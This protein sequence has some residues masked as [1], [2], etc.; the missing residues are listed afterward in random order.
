MFVMTSFEKLLKE[1][2]DNAKVTKEKDL[3]ETIVE[4]LKKVFLNQ[5]PT[6]IDKNT[7]LMKLKAP[8]M[9][10][11]YSGEGEE[12]FYILAF[13]GKKQHLKSL[14]ELMKTFGWNID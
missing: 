13:E 5:V 12:S 10:V 6:C 1:R 8:L 14:K 7:E 9:W 3:K 4:Y 11:T 2:I